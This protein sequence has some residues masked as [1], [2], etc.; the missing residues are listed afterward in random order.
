MPNPFSLGMIGSC[1]CRCSADVCIRAY[2]CIGA[3]ASQTPNGTLLSGLTLTL[4]NGAN[5][6]AGGINPLDV[7]GGAGCGSVDGG[8]AY[9]EVLW[10]VPTAQYACSWDTG[11]AAVIQQ[12]IETM[13]YYA[14]A[15]ARIDDGRCEGELFLKGCVRLPVLRLL[16]PPLVQISDPRHCYTSIIELISP[17]PRP[18]LSRAAASSPFSSRTL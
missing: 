16:H 14:R 11:R 1:A 12:P 5:G 7:P 17:A 9:D 10:A 15:T 2:N 3:N 13:T 4:P 8:M 18:A 6:A